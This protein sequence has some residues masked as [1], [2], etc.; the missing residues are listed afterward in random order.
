MTSVPKLET[1]NSFFANDKRAKGLDEG[2]VASK[3]PTEVGPLETHD[4]AP[5][6]ASNSMREDKGK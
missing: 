5:E 2:G 4:T 3:N 1:R 6:K